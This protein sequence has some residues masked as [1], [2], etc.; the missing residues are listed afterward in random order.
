MADYTSSQSGNWSSSAT[1]GGS[2]VP[3]DGDTATI[4]TGHTVTL[5]Q[6]VTVGTGGS[7]GTD[8]IVVTGTLQANIDWVLT[9]KG[10]MRVNGMVNMQAGGCGIVSEG[11]YDLELAANSTFRLVGTSGNRAS[12]GGNT[13]SGLAI[14]QVQYAG[15]LTVDVQYCDIT[16]IGRSASVHGLIFYSNYADGSIHFQ[17]CKFDTYW[18]LRYGAGTTPNAAAVYKFTRCFFINPQH[19]DGSQYYA[20]EY[21]TTP[22][23]NIDTRG[24][25]DCAFKGRADAQ[26]NIVITTDQDW[27]N[28]LMLS[29]L[30]LDDCGANNYN[31]ANVDITLV[32]AN[33]D[34]TPVRGANMVI[35]GSKRA[36]AYIHDSVIYEKCENPHVLST[37]NTAAVSGTKN[38]VEDC[39]V[40]GISTGWDTGDC[41]LYGALDIDV[42]RNITVGGVGVNTTSPGLEG[43]GVLIERHTHFALDKDYNRTYLAGSETNLSA[44]GITLRSSLL[45]GVNDSV[46]SL[47]RGLSGTQALAYTDYNCFYN[48]GGTKYYQVSVSGKI[49]GDAGFGGSDITDN[50]TLKGGAGTAWAETMIEDWDDSL[51]GGGTVG[52]ALNEMIKSL[53]GFDKTG[54]GA[55]GNESYTRTSLLAYIKDKCTPTAAAIDGAGYNGDDIGAVDYVE[56]GGGSKWNGITPAKWNG[57][58]WSNIKWNGM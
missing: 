43:A 27:D 33:T 52:N 6:D 28:P 58:D 8:E 45:V 18:R 13:G 53:V 50:P 29:N 20:W 38:R 15:M 26:C 40:I 32:C 30:V 19:Y 5:D 17:Y 42:K 3:G 16:R 56:E 2:G 9:I 51:G 35:I 23:F 34:R 39:A 24:L 7:G 54:A 55:T 36:A 44:S 14:Y 57:I 22:G 48:G 10:D 31:G 1:W 37:T 25:F 49:L 11:D 21:T 12:L 4:A 41:I 47:F 46:G